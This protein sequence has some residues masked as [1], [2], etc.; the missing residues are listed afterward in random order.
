MFGFQN[1]GITRMPWLGKSIGSR[2]RLSAVVG[3]KEI[4]DVGTAIN[5]YTVAETR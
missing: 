4:L 2:S 5:M 3:R 1:W